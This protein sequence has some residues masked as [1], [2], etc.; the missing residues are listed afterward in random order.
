MREKVGNVCPEID[1][2]TGSIG[3]HGGKAMPKSLHHDGFE[4]ISFCLVIPLKSFVLVRVNHGIAITLD[5]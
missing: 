5:M 1:I 3:S 2:F 4:H